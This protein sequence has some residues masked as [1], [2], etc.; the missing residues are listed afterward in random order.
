M[1]ETKRLDNKEI[2]GL[3]D[4]KKLDK[5]FVD[6]DYTV[7]NFAIG[8]KNSI[9]ILNSFYPKMG[10]EINKLFEL[11]LRGKRGEENLTKDEKMEYKKTMEEISKYQTEIAPKY[12]LKYWS[13]ETM[14]MMVGKKLNLDL[15]AHKI[16]KLRKI[17][18]KAVT[19][20]WNFFEDAVLFLEKIKKEKI[21]IV[22]VTGS[23]SI[24]KVKR[25]KN[26]VEL[27]YD[28]KYSW[29]EKSKRLKKLLRKYPGK[30]IIGDPVDKPVIWD[31]IFDEKI[32]KNKEKLLVVGD[33][34]ATDLAP[35]EK[36]GI[37]TILIKRN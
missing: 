23:D 20:A 17:Y 6:I 21:K 25:T 34:Y 31:K 18:W 19:E 35:A 24:L 26:G 14:I 5:V 11:I 12:G 32:L 15:N 29:K 2:L 3:I 4:K 10:S 22:W 16:I 7:F 8:N 9:G 37:K 30:L 36:L 28:P 13:R 33:S 27:N 1:I